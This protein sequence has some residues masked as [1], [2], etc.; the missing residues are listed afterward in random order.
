MNMIL[1]ICRMIKK[2][3]SLR[4][5]RA[6]KAE[7]RKRDKAASGRKYTVQIGFEWSM[8]EVIPI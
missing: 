8:V 5:A 7:F 1:L 4:D 3:G 2:L 6:N